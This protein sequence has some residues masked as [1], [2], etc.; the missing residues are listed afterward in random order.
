MWR[1]SS[2]AQRTA[3][4]YLPLLL[5]SL[6]LLSACE[7]AEVTTPEG[8]DL[9]VVEAV[10]NAGQ[11]RQV[12]LLHR[13]LLGNVVR[14]E[15]GARVTVQT[16]QGEVVLPAVP[17]ELC[18]DRLSSFREDEIEV[19]ASCYS[20]EFNGIPGATYEL[21]VVSSDGLTVR[22]RTT[23]PGD[24]DLRQPS[25]PRNSSC[26]LPPATNLPLVW[27]ASSGAWAYLARLEVRGLREAF[28]GAGIDA[29]EILHLTGL[30]ISQNDTTIVLPR[31]FGLFDRFG[32]PDLLI[33]LQS[34][35]PPGVW[36][37]VVISAADRN[38]VNGVRGGA[39][40]PSGNVRISSVVGDGVGMFGSI[41]PRRLSV[42]VERGVA[43][44]CL[45]PADPTGPVG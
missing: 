44:P 30:A 31:E 35:F 32:E 12:V 27:S 22:G 7:L 5:C 23:V 37:V 4:S 40:N 38:F 14:G 39:F 2:P 36:A 16:P 13:T 34:G 28:R 25:R 41:V 17:L 29:P 19:Q 45:A 6:I 26:A 1:G 33:A 3:I 10:I 11:S 15:P 21:R 43:P 8:R 24:F 9:L 42:Q 18:T 20:A